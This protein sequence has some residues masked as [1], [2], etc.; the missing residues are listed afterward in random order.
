MH[1]YRDK[2]TKKLWLSQEKYIEQVLERFNIENAKPLK[3]PFDGHFKLSKKIFPSTKKEK[4]SMIVVPY[5]FVVRSLIYA[6][7][8]IRLT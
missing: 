6:I 8:C 3:T 1:I 7:V 4:E 2:K 5:Y